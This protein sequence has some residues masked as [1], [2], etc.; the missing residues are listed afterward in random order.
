MLF[1]KT[2]KNILKSKNKFL[3]SLIFFPIVGFSNHSSTSFNPLTKENNNFILQKPFTTSKEIQ[4]EMEK[5]NVF[6]HVK[7]YQQ[8]DLNYY[9]S[10]KINDLNYSLIPFQLNDNEEHI[11]FMDKGSCFSSKS[12]QQDNI[13]KDQLI[14]IKNV[15]I[16]ILNPISQRL[17]IDKCLKENQEKNKHGDLV[18]K[19]YQSFILN[20]NYSLNEKNTLSHF[21]NP[22]AVIAD[23]WNSGKEMETEWFKNNINIKFW[24]NSFVLPSL[25]LY[26]IDKYKN[27]I[28]NM[29]NKIINED[30]FFVFG[31]GNQI[32]GVQ[33]DSY[34]L[35]QKIKSFLY[36]TKQISINQKN[37]FFKRLTSDLKEHTNIFYSISQKLL[38]NNLK[39]SKSIL[40]AGGYDH[41]QHFMW[42]DIANTYQNHPI[43]QLEDNKFIYSKLHKNEYFKGA[44]NFCLLAKENCLL[45]DIS[46]L[47]EQ[48][49][50]KGTSF[51][52]SRVLYTAYVLKKTF[53]FL[54]NEQLGWLILSNATNINPNLPIPNEVY[55]YGVLNLN[56]SLKLF[57]KMNNLELELDREFKKEQSQDLTNIRI[58]TFGNELVGKLTLKAIKENN[59]QYI[60]TNF[61][62]QKNNFKQEDSFNLNIGKNNIVIYQNEL[63]KNT[64]IKNEGILF[65]DLS[66][67]NNEIVKSNIKNKGKL[68]FIN[69]KQHNVN[70]LIKNYL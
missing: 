3:L 64:F 25:D 69:F 37:D 51:S 48:E 52:T 34:K 62:T 12:I 15:E 58:Y 56:K 50:K 8:T 46:L 20:P 61:K 13:Q 63:D 38:P 44:S 36:N 70:D 21:F 19:T 43:D 57:S 22:T 17:S 40:F 49:E 10:Q 4:L 66:L 53:P 6:D 11:G 35:E 23:N 41:N 27:V 30:N 32:S 68:I 45:A 55:G 29:S 1:N 47:T 26:N 18:I 28:N 14:K 31:L 7:I 54:T 33:T 39:T 24:N 16:Q 59:K 5:N 67:K 2:N 42:D 60:L 65:L 9:L